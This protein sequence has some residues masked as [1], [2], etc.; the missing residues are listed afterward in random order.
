[1]VKAARFELRAE[2]EQTDVEKGHAGYTGEI[3]KLR[4]RIKEVE[5]ELATVSHIH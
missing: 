3:R 2:P 1:M 5:H 4:K